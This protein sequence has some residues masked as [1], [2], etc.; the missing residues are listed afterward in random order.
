MHGTAFVVEQRVA[1]HTIHPEPRRGLVGV[2]VAVD[3]DQGEARQALG[4][5]G[6]AVVEPVVAATP[7]ATVRAELDVERTYFRSLG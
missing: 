2:Q 1:R 4:D 3:L 5:L 7:R 6:V